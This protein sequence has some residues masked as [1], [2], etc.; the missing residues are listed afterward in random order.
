MMHLITLANAQR[1]TS[2]SVLI[3]TNGCRIVASSCSTTEQRIQ[4][5]LSMCLGR[6]SSKN[7]IWYYKSLC[8]KFNNTGDQSFASYALQLRIRKLI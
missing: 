7:R 4:R 5:A 2:L 6:G 3:N 8:S 1:I